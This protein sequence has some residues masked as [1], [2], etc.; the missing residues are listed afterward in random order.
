M[1]AVARRRQLAKRRKQRLPSRIYETT[2]TLA[3]QFAPQGSQAEQ[4]ATEQRNGRVAIGHT[5]RR[6]NAAAGDAVY[7]VTSEVPHDTLEDSATR[8][9][10]QH[11]EFISTNAV[12]EFQRLSSSI[13]EPIRVPLY[14]T[15]MLI[16]GIGQFILVRN[17]AIMRSLAVNTRIRGL[18][19]RPQIN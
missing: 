11:P 3:T 19:Y 14:Y 15:A 6:S 7:R 2:K 9:A 12:P 17:P 16:P 10:H 1:K 13:L 18:F 4:S 8:E 5:S